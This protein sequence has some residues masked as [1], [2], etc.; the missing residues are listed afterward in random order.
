VISLFLVVT[1]I[2]ILKSYVLPA[3][4]GKRQASVLTM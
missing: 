3:V 4:G 1:V 2:G